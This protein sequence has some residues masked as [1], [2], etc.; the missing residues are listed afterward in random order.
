MDWTLNRQNPDMVH[1]ILQMLRM[2]TM[3]WQMR[4]HMSTHTCSD[5]QARVYTYIREPYYSHGEGGDR[6]I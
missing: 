5:A 6:Y 4:M 2:L 3:C 1:D